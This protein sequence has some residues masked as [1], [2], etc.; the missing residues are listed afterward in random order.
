MNPKH[1]VFERLPCSASI[2]FLL[3]N[4][5][6]QLVSSLPTTIKNDAV[7]QMDGAPIWGRGYSVTT[8][9][10]Q[11]SCMVDLNHTAT[12]P[13]YNYD[14]KYRKYFQCIAFRNKSSYH[15][16]LTNEQ[17]ASLS[18]VLPTR[19]TVTFT[20][21]FTIHRSSPLQSIESFDNSPLYGFH[22]RTK[23]IRPKPPRSN[24]QSL[25]LSKNQ[26]IRP[27]LLLPKLQL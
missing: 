2:G 17:C 21:T 22:S 18:F 16:F 23:A 14:C 5:Y 20:F 4:H 6:F 9:S 26:I 7:R 19:F 1:L 12:E 3:L 10:F 8:N 27:S 24:R 11:T 13:S 25:Q 15:R